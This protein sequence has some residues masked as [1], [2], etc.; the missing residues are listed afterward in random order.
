VPVTFFAATCNSRNKRNEYRKPKTGMFKICKEEIY[1]YKKVDTRDSFFCGDAAGRL[2]DFADS[3]L[4]FAIGNSLN[5][6]TP[7]MFFK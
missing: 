4:K 2:S 5:F 7:E 1:G 3:D 6:V